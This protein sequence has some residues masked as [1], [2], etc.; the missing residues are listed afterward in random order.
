MAKRKAVSGSGIVNTIVKAVN[1]VAEP[2][3]PFV[4]KHSFKDFAKTLATAPDTVQNLFLESLANLGFLQ[5]FVQMR[6]Y[7]SYF[8]KLYG[9]DILQEQ[10][11]LYCV[12]RIKARSYDPEDVT[13]FL[14]SH[15]PRVGSEIIQSVLRRQY[16]LSTL[17]DIISAIGQGESYF[18]TFY[19]AAVT[20]MWNSYE[21]DNLLTI[22]EMISEQIKE[23][24]L[25][26]FPLTKPTNQSTVLAMKVE[27][28]TIT[29]DWASELDRGYNLAGF[30]THTPE[31]ELIYLFNN[32][33]MSLN[34]NYNLAWAYNEQFLDLKKDGRAISMK[35]DGLAG[36]NVYAAVFDR[37]AFEIHN[38]VGHPRVTGF[39]NPG[40][41]ENE[42]ILTCFTIFGMNLFA[43]SVWFID[44]SAI[45]FDATTPA[46]LSTRDG[47][48]NANLGEVKEVYVS[49]IKADTGKYADKFGK[50][51]ITGNTSDDTY[52][53]PDSGELYIAKDEEG[54]EGT[55]ADAGSYFITVTWTSHLDNTVTA[56]LAIKLNV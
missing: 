21:Y 29:A 34:S 56:T 54:T 45:G 5:K 22:K 42:R 20:A 19:D 9:E 41:L 14:E 8:R 28:D 6:E 32:R 24:N 44:P 51:S 25:R 12:D 55:G 26:L 47:S 36:G 4:D 15:P 23:G 48:V 3:L 52:I 46:T 35:S 17:E 11:V 1:K 16:Q 38:R 50:F 31:D 40:T 43:N 2:Q 33:I 7:E 27:V 30:A 49:A 13:R 39:F 53:D 18:V 10:L 37:A